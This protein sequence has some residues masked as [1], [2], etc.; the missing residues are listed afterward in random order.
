[1]SSKISE[2][3]DTKQLNLLEYISHVFKNAFVF[4]ET[5][6]SLTFFSAK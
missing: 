5:C 3:N 2:L 1:M 4:S 6:T